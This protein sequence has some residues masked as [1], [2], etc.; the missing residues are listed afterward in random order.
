MTH[1]GPKIQ[2]EDDY[3]VNI[4]IK[5]IPLEPTQNDVEFP[6]KG[7]RYIHQPGGYAF[8]S[9]RTQLAGEGGLVR[10]FLTNRNLPIHWV[11]L[12]CIEYVGFAWTFLC[13]RPP[14]VAVTFP[15]WWY[16]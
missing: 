8:E 10:V 3:A 13:N 15:R 11:R 2:A 9:M 6:L 1:V 4:Y 12:V 16:H 5:R 7:C 14:G